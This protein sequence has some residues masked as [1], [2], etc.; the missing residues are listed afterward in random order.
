M[1]PTSRLQSTEQ[2]LSTSVCICLCICIF[3]LSIFVY[4][5]ES[6]VEWCPHPPA[7]RALNSSCQLALVFAFEYVFNC[8]FVFV[9]FFLFVFVFVFSNVI[10]QL[11]VPTPPAGRALSNSCQLAPPSLRASDDTLLTPQTV[12]SRI[13]SPRTGISRILSQKSGKYS[14]QNNFCHCPS[15]WA[16]DA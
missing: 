10:G 2:R 16:S 3:I 15:L 7:A 13:F 8:V 11:G 5:F 4:V 1:S 12:F 6:I 14:S 9:F